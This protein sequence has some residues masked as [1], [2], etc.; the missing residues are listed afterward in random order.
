MVQT[1]QFS[2][3][4]PTALAAKAVPAEPYQQ[5]TS[6]IKIVVIVHVQNGSWPLTAQ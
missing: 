5:N 1:G 2:V 4:V 6:K 3:A